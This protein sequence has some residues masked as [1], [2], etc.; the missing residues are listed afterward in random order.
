MS[1]IVST[2][3]VDAGI[4]DW[5]FFQI[6]SLGESYWDYEYPCVMRKSHPSV[7]ISVKK[8]SVISLSH[9]D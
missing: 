9:M 1:I 5:C 4:L 6:F 8:E 2:R 3:L 7:T